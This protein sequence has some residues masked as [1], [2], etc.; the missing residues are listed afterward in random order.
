MDQTQPFHLGS[1]PSPCEVAWLAGNDI[2]LLGG[3]D[4]GK[5][6]MDGTIALHIGDN[7]GHSGI[8]CQPIWLHVYFRLRIVSRN[9]LEQ[10]VERFSIDLRTVP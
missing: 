10:A 9:L 6:N 1:L 2:R 4:S 8:C 7:P 3:I 5:A